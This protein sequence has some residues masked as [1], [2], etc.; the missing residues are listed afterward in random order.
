M[1]KKSSLTDLKNNSFFI[2][3]LFFSFSTFYF[4]LIHPVFFRVGCKGRI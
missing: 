4:N 1:F 2:V 3:F